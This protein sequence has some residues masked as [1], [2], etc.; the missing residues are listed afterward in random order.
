VV[1]QKGR[2]CQVLSK[3]LGRGSDRFGG[4]SDRS[5]EAVIVKCLISRGSDQSRQ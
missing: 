4:G 1:A 2:G 5:K 3:E